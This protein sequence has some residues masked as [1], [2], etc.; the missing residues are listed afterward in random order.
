MVVQ[1]VKRT[2]LTTKSRWMFELAAAAFLTLCTAVLVGG[3]THK[4][5]SSAP[6]LSLQASPLPLAS[7][8]KH[9]EAMAEFV[10]KFALSRLASPKPEIAVPPKPQA[11]ELP[12]DASLVS[13]KLRAPRDAPVARERPRLTMQRPTAA[14]QTPTRAIERRATQLADAR[15]VELPSP[16]RSGSRIPVISDIAERIPSG[17]EIAN[18][19]TSGVSSLGRRVTSLFGRG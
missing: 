19:V 7:T 12:M 3:Y 11:G 14:P 18:G 1:A 13:A 15:Q 5:R 4:P 17:R 10:E 6:K 9:D 16:P 8:S 2:H